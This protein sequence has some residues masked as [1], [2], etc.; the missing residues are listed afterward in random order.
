MS[1]LGVAEMPSGTNVNFEQMV[2]KSPINTM[3]ATP[4]GILTYMNAASSS[5]LKTLEQYLPDRVENLVGKSIDWFHRDPEVQK[6][7]IANPANLPYKGIIEVGPEKLDLLV[8]AIVSDNGTYLGPM[9]TWEVVTEAQKL[10]IEMARIRQ[11]V[12]KSPINTMMANPDGNL[13][14]MNEASTNTLR[15]LEQYLP[16]K[17]DNLVGNSI[18]WFHK[19]PEVQ[20]KIIGNPSNLPH[21]AIISVGPEKLDLLV[22]PILATDGTYLGPMVTWEVVTK[23]LETETEMARTSQMVEKSP[24]NTMMATP[25][26]VMI[27]MNESS[28]T[29]LKGL[30]QYLPDRVDN[31][32]GKSIDW[33]H[34]NPEGPRKIFGNPA[35]L[36]HKAV[37]SVGPEKLDLLVSAIFDSSG[38]YLGPMVTWDVITDKYALVDDLSKSAQGLSD[39]AEQLLAL[40]NSLSAGAEETSAQANTAS[41]ASEEINAGVQTVAS[42]ME[43]M[44]AAI[45][46]ITKT[47][48]EASSMSNEAMKMAKSTNE[49]IGQL[50]ESSMDIGN[51]IKV[52]SSI[53]QQT[54][55]LALNATIEAARAG[56]AGK[57]FAV[58]A[59]EVKELAKQTAKATNDITKK[60][61]T[62]QSDSKNAVN[63]IG[64]ISDAIE[65]VNGYAGNIAA[66]VEEQAATTNEVT[67]IVTE[68]A[69]GVKQINENIGQVSEAAATTGKDAANTQDAAKLL[70]EMADTLQVHVDKIE[71]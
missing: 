35:N 66:S 31:L 25:E 49:I 48:N 37:I 36:P 67:R 20:R 21:S 4:E 70:R 5:T 61:E 55:L 32:V 11:M 26:G 18:D 43:E 45:K 15:T 46:E 22:S 38:E 69:E 64:E 28:R 52:I 41:T 53:A 3:F 60:I 50:G 9:V 68:A 65:K 63:A 7:I 71:I 19:D 56:E 59:N 17:V 57:G 16:D 1:N 23:K 44:V 40:S 33:L 27:Y 54:N 10:E 6:K 8:T 2:E 58:V 24:I 62:I 42:N 51:V 39:S 14:Y 29:T 12:D 13:L 30:E 34:K 47:T